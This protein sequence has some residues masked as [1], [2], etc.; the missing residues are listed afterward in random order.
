[1]NRLRK[2]SKYIFMAIIGSFFTSCFLSSLVFGISPIQAGA[3]AAQGGNLPTNLFGVAGIFTTI[4]NIMMFIIGA[5]S[6][7]MLIIGGFRYVISGGDA[8][9]VTKAKNTILYAIVGLIV[10][11]LAYAAINFVLVTLTPSL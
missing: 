3:L 7:L 8:S 11:L 2:I 9:A 1:M 5:L 4:S 6:V 10:A